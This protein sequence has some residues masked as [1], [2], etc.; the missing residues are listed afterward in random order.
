MMA[1]IVMPV[2]LLVAHALIM[3]VNVPQGFMYKIINVSLV[4]LNARLVPQPILVQ[5]AP[6]LIL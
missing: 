6:V 1:P 5:A 3:F 4:T 2:M